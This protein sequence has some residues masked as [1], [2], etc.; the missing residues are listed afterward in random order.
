MKMYGFIIRNCRNF[1]DIRPIKLLYLSLVRTKLEYCS[2]I[3]YP[4]C[5]C[6]MQQIKKVQRKLFNIVSLELGRVTFSV[7]F[8]Y[9]LLHNCI[10]CSDILGQIRFIV[11]YGI[12]LS[13]CE[14]KYVTEVTHLYYVR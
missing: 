14:N 1:S 8:L 2:L 12:Y 4:I 13:R 10:D 5:K 3:W 9:K 7:S 6:Y 11:Y